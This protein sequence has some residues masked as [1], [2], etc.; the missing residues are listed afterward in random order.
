MQLYA[1]TTQKRGTGVMRRFLY[2]SSIC[3]YIM[4]TTCFMSASS[5]A[6]TQEAPT[7]HQLIAPFDTATYTIKSITYNTITKHH[8]FHVQAH[9]QIGF[10]WTYISQLETGITITDDGHNVTHHT[11]H[12]P[13]RVPLDATIT[14]KNG[15]IYMEILQNERIA[16][17]APT[18]TVITNT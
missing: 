5:A 12:M 11:L 17:H 6:K 2:L 18:Q 14:I 10:T 3:C 8:I 1:H 15:H 7:Y 13:Y 9:T 4:A 16:R